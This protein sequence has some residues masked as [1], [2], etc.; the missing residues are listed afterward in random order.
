MQHENALVFDSHKS[1]AQVQHVKTVWK[2]SDYWFAKRDAHFSAMKEGK[3]LWGDGAP[4]VE[5][6]FYLRF[7]KKQFKVSKEAIWYMFQ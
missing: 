3:G 1:G 5:E 2:L 7:Q 6:N 4:Q